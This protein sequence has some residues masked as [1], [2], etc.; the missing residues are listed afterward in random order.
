MRNELERKKPIQKDEEVFSS[1]N[2]RK[3]PGLIL[4]IIIMRIKKNN[5]EFS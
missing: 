3:R 5:I 4:I 1:L 2:Q